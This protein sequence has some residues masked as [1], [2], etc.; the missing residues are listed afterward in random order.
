MS[1]PYISVRLEKDLLTQQ[2]R[3]NGTYKYSKQAHGQPSWESLK[4][5]GKSDI[6][7]N[8][9]WKNPKTSNWLIGRVKDIGKNK[10]KIRGSVISTR[11]TPDKCTVWSY[12]KGAAWTPKK[13]TRESGII[14]TCIEGKKFL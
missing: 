4:F 10:G 12:Q 7:S 5:N 2:K 1:C 14:V 6:Y 9:I 11:A 13:P 8:A 3:F